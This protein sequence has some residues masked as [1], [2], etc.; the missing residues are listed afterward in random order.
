ME[1]TSVVLVGKLAIVFAAL[2]LSLRAGLK[3]TKSMLITIVATIVLYAIPLKDTIKI[4]YKASTSFNTISLV[5]ILYLITLLQRILQNRKQLSQV[6]TNLDSLF[7]SRRITATVAPIFIGLLPSAAAMLICGE[8]VRDTV[9]DALDQEEQAFITSY[10]RHIPESFL[11]T[12]AAVILMSELS[13]VS[14]GTFVLGMLPLEV[15]LYILGYWA[16]IRRIPKDTGLPPSENR[17]HV[18]VELLKNLWSIIA[19]IVLVIGFKWSVLSATLAVIIVCLPVYRYKP[20]EI[21]PL[22]KDAVEAPMLVNTYLIM[23]FKDFI[24]HSGAMDAL[25]DFFSHLPVPTYLVFAL[26]FFFG[27][28]VAGAQAIIAICAVMA[29]AAIPGGGMPLMVLLMSFAYAAMQISPTHICLFIAA[30]DFD[31]P[32]MALVR[33]TMPIIIVFCL[34]T[35]PYYW[36][37]TAFF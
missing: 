31:V 6:H 17:G 27:T 16:Y 23:V 3:L 8:I 10:F 33:K 18:A 20:R 11:P 9:G 36:L 35:V 22:L 14:I 5:L 30:D 19:I 26:I 25:P 15:L 37:L 4:W 24:M 13:G 2:L 28:V 1:P 21:L 34:L 29:F 12:Y 32:M 7:N